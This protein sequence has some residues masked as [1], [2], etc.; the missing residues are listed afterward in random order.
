MEDHPEAYYFDTPTA[1]SNYLGSEHVERVVGTSDEFWSPLLKNMNDNVIPDSAPG[2]W[3]A[4]NK[5]KG[6]G[7]Q[8]A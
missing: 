8:N 5:T 1:S 4:R 2:N 3:C 6:D 7:S